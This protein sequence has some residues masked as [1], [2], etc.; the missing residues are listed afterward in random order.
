MAFYTGNF[1]SFASLKNSVETALQAN[2]WVLN[3]D[4]VL[5]KSDMYLRLTATTPQLLLQAGTG[6]ACSR[7]SLFG[8]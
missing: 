2:G 4:G 5:N 8:K 6:T 1:S 7:K 3:G